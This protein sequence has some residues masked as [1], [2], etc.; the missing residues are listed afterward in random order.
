M[1][2]PD[3][4]S[5]EFAR[6]EAAALWCVR[7]SEGQM[8]G[9]ARVEFTHWLTS[10]P[11]HRAAFDRAVAVWEE[12]NA[13]EAAPEILALRV[14]ALESLRRAQRARAGRR[15]PGMRMPWML[16][17]S[18]VIAV[19]VGTGLWWKPN[20]QQFSS[21]I[22]E[23]QTVVLNDGSTVLLDAASEVVVRYSRALRELHLRRGRAEFKVAR[24]ARRPFVV[25][26]ADREVV[27]TGT[28]FSVEI[29]RKEILVALYEGHVS[30]VG[31]GQ[32]H[33][34]L[35]A[36]QELIAPV[37][38][39]QVQIAAVD[40]IRAPSWTGGLLEF[41]DEPLATAV[42]RVNRYTRNPISIGDAAAAN[43]HISGVFAAGDTR[44][45]I[46]GVTAVSPV[47]TEV[48]NGRDVLLGR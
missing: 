1:S 29:I 7:L 14:E 47:R 25:Y 36:G 12:V 22:G 24:D 28:T 42:E 17:A 38:R 31:P 16:A 8:T 45:F 4:Q 35:S 23:R 18:V 10:D 33:T 6:S 34:P 26:A 30:V 3:P 43:V 19:L 21:G 44:A 20:T 2:T 41:V 13:V 46:E 37:S 5:P 48:R 39:S 27:A 9:A 15:L 11:R 32:V 40:T